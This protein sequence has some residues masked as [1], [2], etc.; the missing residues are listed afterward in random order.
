MYNLRVFA[1]KNPT[2]G[3]HLTKILSTTSTIS[4]NICCSSKSSSDTGHQIP[5]RLKDVAT[6]K[7]PKFFDMVEYFFHR[8][9][10]IAEKRFVE[11]MK[12]ASLEER[13]KK[14]KGILMLIE[15]CDS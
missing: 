8:A 12:G 15:G 10:Q 7:D 4:R 3:H 13:Q 1:A 6:A 2:I 14:T 5:E 11:E 9:C